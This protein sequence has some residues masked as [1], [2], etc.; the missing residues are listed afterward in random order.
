MS[1]SDLTSDKAAESKEI[2]GKEDLDS[3]D[4]SLDAILSEAKDASP[5]PAE[6]KSAAEEAETVIPPPA[7]IQISLAEAPSGSEVVSDPGDKET[8]LPVIVEDEEPSYKAFADMVA[9]PEEPKDPPV[10]ES[11]AV[12]AASE[13]AESGEIL[14]ADALIDSMTPAPELVDGEPVASL[15]KTEESQAFTPPPPPS[16]EEI[17]DHVKLPPGAT[18]MPLVTNAAPAPGSTLGDD[19]KTVISPMPPVPEPSVS[20]PPPP[21]FTSAW[22]QASASEQPPSI[23]LA[24]E[25]LGTKVRK[26]AASRVQTSVATLAVV[27]I[28]SCALGA[29]VMRMA[30]PAPATPLVVTATSPAKAEPAVKP[31]I[32]PL[33]AAEAPAPAEPAKPAAAAAAPVVADKPEKTE[34]ADKPEKTEKVEKP[35]AAKPAV[36]KAKPAAAQGTHIALAAPAA[37]PAAAK[38]KPAAPKGKKAPASSAGW[39]DPF[40]Q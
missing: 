34:K 20:L 30:S 28:G 21:R 10:L 2:G 29:G 7:D 38:A 32:A 16:D 23:V 40:G 14:D 24:P 9:P 18:P 37:K 36:A 1:S 39:V 5:A 3:I 26:V 22:A 19:D 15:A 6:G 35:A 17:L 25:G 13:E 33:P 4:A 8:P 12:T 11:V 31:A 27:V